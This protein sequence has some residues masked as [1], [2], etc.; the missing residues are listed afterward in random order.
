[1]GYAALKSLIIGSVEG[2]T[3]VRYTDEGFTAVERDDGPQ[4]RLDD[5]TAMVPLRRFDLRIVEPPQ[6]DGEAGAGDLR[7]RTKVA[8]RMAYR[9]DGDI[10]DTESIIAE[11]MACALNTLINMPTVS[12]WATAGGCSVTPPG[13]P[14]TEPVFETQDGRQI[15]TIVS[16]PFDLLYVESR[17]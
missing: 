1:M 11:D 3:P 5:F 9:I 17:S 8:L 7:V 6:D 13:V 15:G 16:M 10:G 14:T 4:P 12:G 2:S